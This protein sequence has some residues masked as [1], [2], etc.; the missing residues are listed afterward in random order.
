MG[1][2]QRD[3]TADFRVVLTLGVHAL[4]ENR[5]DSVRPL[6]KNPTHD[7]LMQSLPWFW[8]GAPTAGHRSAGIHP[9]ET[10]SG[11]KLPIVG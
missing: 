11:Y 10:R 1:A 9:G 4:S 2:V 3:K 5:E 8:S 7:D 6:R